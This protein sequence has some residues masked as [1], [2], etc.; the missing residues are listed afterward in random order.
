MAYASAVELKDFLYVLA[1]ISFPPSPPSDLWFENIFSH[2]G[3]FSSPGT[4]SS[5]DPILE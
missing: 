3:S 4:T 1:I 5:T 2:L